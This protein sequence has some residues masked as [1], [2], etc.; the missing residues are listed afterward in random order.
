MESNTSFR[1]LRWLLLAI[2]VCVGGIQGLAQT[3]TA[4]SKPTQP[5]TTAPVQRWHGG[6]RTIVD[7]AGR[8]HV[9]HDRIT[10]AQRKA[11]AQRRV[12]AMRLATAKKG[13]AEVKQ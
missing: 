10:Y 3:K 4:Q 2:A 11:A 13:Q 5:P 8:P 6:Q 7:A 12:Q 1:F 9:R